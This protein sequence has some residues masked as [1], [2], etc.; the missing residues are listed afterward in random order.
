MEDF[1]GIS[2][3]EEQEEE[4]EDRSRLHEILLFLLHHTLLRIKD[5][6]P[7][8]QFQVLKKG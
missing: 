6:P 5:E 2:P 1:G 7:L 8:K 3:Q 4:D